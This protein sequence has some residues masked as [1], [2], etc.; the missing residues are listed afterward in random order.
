M[1]KLL[2]QLKIAV[3]IFAGFIVLTFIAAMFSVNLAT[4]LSMIMTFAIP[5][6]AL[7]FIA[8]V[9]RVLLHKR[10]KKLE[11]SSPQPNSESID[12]QS[13]NYGHENKSQVQSRNTIK[14]SISS[15]TKGE[16][17]NSL[18]KPTVSEKP[19]GEKSTPS[20]EEL[21]DQLGVKVTLKPINPNYRKS[22]DVKPKILVHHLRRKLYNFVVVDTETT[23]LSRSKAKVIQLSA[24]KYMHDKPVDTFN[25][26]INPGNLP[27]PEAISMKTGISDDQLVNAPEFNDVK[28]KFLAFVGTLPWVG[29][30][31]NSFDLPIL[32]NNG[33][34]LT[35]VSTLDTLKLARKKLSM[36]HYTLENL[37]DY[38][39]I[40]HLS[41]NA[42]EDCKTT[43][44]VYQHL[45]DDNLTP[46]KKDYSSIPQTLSGLSFAISGA[47]PGLSRSN[48]QKMIT[49]HGGII[50][51]NVTHNTDY[52]VDGKQ[53]SD[54]L[55]DGVHSGKELKARDY[56]T[57]ILSLSELRSLIKGEYKQK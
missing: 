51:S 50:K 40:D 37:K 5:L 6:Y 55:T 28:D 34:D 42:L 41:H 48:I 13:K 35:E 57:N 25:T 24:I 30:N 27:L 4:S 46:A 29:H 52:L 1:K 45:R 10:S 44:I 19:E 20:A 23:G 53:T 18:S 21:L 9:V 14:D 17:P 12:D 38:F 7:Y 22:N 2:G 15:K 49:S 54:V 32:V 43:A 16:E 11:N 33:L 56:G 3:L 39:S 47:F 36:E 26:F 31:I 8:M